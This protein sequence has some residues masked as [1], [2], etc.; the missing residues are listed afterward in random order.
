MNILVL[1]CSWTANRLVNNNITTSWVE[2]LSKLL[3]EHTFYNFAYSGSSVGHSILVMES[4]LENSKIKFDKIIFQITTDGRI[5]FYNNLDF[6]NLDFF[7]SQKTS[8]YYFLDMDKDNNFLK[9]SNVNYG[10]LNP[11]NKSPR[12]DWEKIKK[13]AEIYYENLNLEYNFFLEHKIQFEYIKKKVD[14]FFLHRPISQSMFAPISYNPNNECFVI[15]EVL[16]NQ[17]FDKFKIDEGGHFSLEG[18]IWEAK[19]LKKK[20]EEKWKI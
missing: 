19:Y 13:F 1:G 7:I 11:K 10:I 16:G 17:I 15:E 2:E 5:T 18:C 9:I 8:N 14:F 20:L 12:P 3:P 6:K 4:L